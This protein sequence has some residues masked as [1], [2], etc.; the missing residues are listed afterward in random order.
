MIAQ[1]MADETPIEILGNGSKR[2][3]GRAV[4]QGLTLD[5]SGLAGVSLYEPEEL[6][7]SAGAGTALAEIEARLGER[8]QMLAF[9]P[10]DY[11][12]LLG[13]PINAQTLG[14][15][16]ACNLAGPRRLRAGAARDHFL[17]FTAVNGRAEIFKA[18]GRVM[19]NVTGYDM[20]KILA[21]SYGTLAVMTDV[22]LKVM[23]APD[24]TRTLLIPGL[25]EH[26]AIAAMIGALQGAFDVSGAAHL[27][28][29]MARGSAAAHEEGAAAGPGLSLTALRLE[30]A[31][32]SVA[33][34]LEGLRAALAEYRPEEVLDTAASRKLWREI[35]DV[36]P[37]VAP[38]DSGLPDAP[39]SAAPII[40]RLS[41]PPAG[42]ARLVATIRAECGCRALYD[43]GGGLV[44]LAI[45][46]AGDA[47]IEAVRGAVAE[48]GGHALIVRAPEALRARVPVFEPQPDPL[49][50]LAWRIKNSFDPLH[51]LNPGRMVADS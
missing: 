12:P 40:W 46:A 35:A 31:S 44:W 29:E 49:A 4:V 15:V 8:D 5:V 7:M 36:E 39:D 45:E 42:A 28:A 9:E 23:P 50:R 6:V 51:I 25:D 41:V 24:E 27:P 32:P 13:A 20:C 1:A 43:W 37:F 19:K 34:R 21:G 11:G 47:R 10:A 17:G 2:A 14:G 26:A 22:T 48:T 3:L 33:A 30:G 18:G 16:I 38:G